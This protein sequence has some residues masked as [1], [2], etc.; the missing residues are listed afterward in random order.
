M[1]LSSGI[2][3]STGAPTDRSPR[4]RGVSSARV[5][6][7]VDSRRQDSLRYN[8]GIFR[9]LQGWYDSYRGVW[10]GKISQFRNQVT[11]PLTFAMIQSDVA[12][13]VQTTFGSWPIVTFEG[14]APEDVGRAKKNEVLISAQMKDANSL[15]HAVDFMLQADICGT[16]VA[17]YGWQRKVRKNRVIRYE[18][19][20]P[21]MRIPV[22]REYDAEIFNGPVWSPIDRLDFWQQPAKKW[23]DDMEWAIHRYWLD[24]DEMMEDSQGETPYF[25]PIA[26]KLLR[27]YPMGSQ[28]QNAFLERRLRF[29][30]EFDYQARQNE[31]FSKPI[32]VWEMQGTVPGDFAPNGIRSRCIAIGNGRVVLK[33]R[34]MAL[35]SLKKT[36]KSYSPMPDPFSFD[37]VGKA[38]VAYGPQ[39]T[40]N[41]LANQKLDALDQLIDPMWVMSNSAHI[42]TQNLFTP[43]GRG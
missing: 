33:N 32:E 38:E 11:I 26:V 21:G 28:A 9:R 39:M 25:D 5:I 36:F 40:V 35:P 34:E 3:L 41:R 37:G 19:I 24:W 6:E 7:L 14:Y 16:G 43:A 27:D 4:A 13:K 30:N 8:A 12:R 23:I 31:R 42:N 15:L 20:A 10:Q 18:P 17:R 22:V 2:N 29:R 1:A